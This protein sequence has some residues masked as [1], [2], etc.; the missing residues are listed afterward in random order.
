MQINTTRFGL[1]D[2]DEKRLVS[3]PDG[4]PGFSEVRR[5]VLV[6]HAPESP[7]HWL[8]SLDDPA[9]AFVV[10]NPILIDP[11]YGEVISKRLYEDLGLQGSEDAAILAIVTI[12]AKNQRV[13]ANLLAPLVINP[14]TRQG[15]QV[16]L[17]NSPYS[18][19]QDLVS[20]SHT[21]NAAS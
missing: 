20:S 5:F 4:L 1:I 9:L 16:I 7:F 18:T 10:M 21:Q 13:T 12:D 11:T 17:E 3:F 19:K 2:I 15:K 6:E 8:Q 14:M